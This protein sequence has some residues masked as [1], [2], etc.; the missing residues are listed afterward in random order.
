MYVLII[1]HDVFTDNVATQKELW[2]IGDRALNEIFYTLPALKKE[3]KTANSTMPYLYNQY[4][5]TAFHMAQSAISNILLRLINSFIEALNKHRLPRMVIFIMDDDILT[6]IIKDDKPGV[7]KNIGTTLEWIT[8]SIEDMLDDKREE[9]FKIRRRSIYHNEPKLIWVSA[10]Q[11]PKAKESSQLLIRKYNDI[12]EQTL[13][14]RKLT[15]FI[16]MTTI[17]TAEHLDK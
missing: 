8:E 4:N 14:N 7:S 9:M 1:Y 10:L 13:Y 16:D 17:I 12:L 6:G 5:F 2:I 15:Y 3:A 11:R